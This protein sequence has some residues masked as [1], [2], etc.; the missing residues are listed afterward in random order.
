MHRRRA[1]RRLRLATWLY[2]VAILR[3]FRAT[4]SV[5]VVLVGVGAI[6]HCL[7]PLRALGGMR[8]TLGGSLYAAW[9]ALLGQPSVGLSEAWYLLLIDALFPLLGF[10]LVGE[11][12]IRFGLLMLSRRRGEKEWMRVMASTY[13]DHVILCG[14]GHLGYRTLGELLANG[15]EVVAIERDPACRFLTQA[16]ATGVPVFVRDMKDDEALI[17]AGI[18]RACAIVI[19][20]NDDLANLEVALDARRLNPRIRIV[21]R[22]FDQQIASKIG[23]A[24]TVDQAFSA[25]ALAAPA[26]AAMALDSKVLASFKVDGTAYLTAEVEVDEHS[27]LIGHTPAELGGGGGV[28]VLSVRQVASPGR[29][30]SPNT[31]PLSAGAVLVVSG[32]AVAVRRLSTG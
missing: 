18:E 15:V 24:L 28:H 21:L 5:L 30:E 12:L 32:P 31:T 23:S 7:T 8:P 6:L 9:M 16:K 19:A 17:E 26:V 29:S 11:G 4:F 25:S 1:R 14:L 22:L 27:P 13:R 3:E 2:I 20:S 10:V